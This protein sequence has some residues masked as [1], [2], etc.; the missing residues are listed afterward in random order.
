MW[1]TAAAEEMVSNGLFSPHIQE[2]S[3]ETPHFFMLSPV[4]PT[5]FLSLFN[6][7]HV[8]YFSSVRVE[9]GSPLA[10]SPWFLGSLCPLLLPST[11]ASC[12]RVRVLV[13][14][15][16]ITAIKRLPDFNLC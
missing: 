16:F 5:I 13:V 10:E 7:R 3:S 12:C 11:A 6:K 4:R 14:R 2:K 9:K 1:A 15:G 8:S